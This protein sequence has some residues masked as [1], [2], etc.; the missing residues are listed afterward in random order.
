MQHFSAY[1]SVQI[2]R[3]FITVTGQLADKPTLGPSSRRLVNSRT[4]QLTKMFYF[5][6]ITL[7][8]RCQYSTGLE[9]GLG[10]GLMYK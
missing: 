6:Q 10:F 4:S 5:G 8:I 7:F 3:T 2:I 1:I 9:L